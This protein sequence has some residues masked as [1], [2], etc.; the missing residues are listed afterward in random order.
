MA[1]SRKYGEV[2]GMKLRLVVW[3]VAMAYAGFLWAGRGVH[4]LTS[5]SISGAIIG[6][7]IGFLLAIMFARRI[8][9]KRAKY[10]M[11]RA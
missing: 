3:T 5:V 9:R 10:H 6:A 7:L 11:T 2:M 8:R 1:R 4:E